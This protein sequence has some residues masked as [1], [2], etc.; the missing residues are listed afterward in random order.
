MPRSPKSGRA[1]S[2]D[3]NFKGRVMNM[4]FGPRETETRTMGRAF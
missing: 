3:G 4:N 2:G 1:S